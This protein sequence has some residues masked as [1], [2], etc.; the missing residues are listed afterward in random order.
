MFMP[1]ELI[2]VSLENWDEIWRRNQFLCS[3]WVRRNGARILF[4]A[5]PIDVTN[6]VRYGK[7]FK[8]LREKRMR[9]VLEGDVRIVRPLKW[10]PTSMSLGRAQNS[11]SCLHAVRGALKSFEMAK[12]ILWINDHSCG[13]LRGRLGESAVV[14]DVTDD[15]TTSGQSPASLQRIKEQDALL[16]RDADAVIVCSERLQEMKRAVAEP[17]LHLIPNGVDARHYQRVLDGKSSLAPDSF[18]W[19][20]PVLGYTGTIHPDRLDVDLIEAMSRRMEKGSLVLI[21]PNH[22]S[23]FQVSRLMRTG[24]VPGAVPYSDIPE[25]MRAFDVC[26]APHVVTPFTESLNPIKLWEYLAA[27]KPIVSTPV[28]GFRDYPEFVYLAS[29]ASDFVAAT[30][31]AL[32]E[33]RDVK[34]ARRAEAMKHSWDARLDQVDAV[35]EQALARRASA[36]RPP[37]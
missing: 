13:Y 9:Y 27:G 19:E 35:I 37:F 7:F 25:W 20:R 5:P 12:P 36:L 16:T 18:K 22:L 34:Q 17:R 15:W 3:G 6:A 8:L 21:G 23:A 1:E 33:G 14:Y 10:Y 4:I 29:S 2:M 26:M 11:K 30:H 31:R 24:R 32:A 28:A